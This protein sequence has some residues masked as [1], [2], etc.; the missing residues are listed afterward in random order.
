[1]SN[2]RDK[3][4]EL[5]PNTL[6]KAQTFKA[7]RLLDDPMLAPIERI[8]S[9]LARVSGRRYPSVSREE[10]AAELI[11]WFAVRARLLLEGWEFPMLAR[12][13]HALERR[14]D[15]LAATGIGSRRRRTPIATVK[16]M[17]SKAGESAPRERIKPRRH[18]NA[19]R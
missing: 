11:K 14:A 4:G 3:P 2:E 8:R 18:E 10:E 13:L 12:E 6:T 7:M 5:P 9:V 17:D 1:M 15:I 16:T 19:K